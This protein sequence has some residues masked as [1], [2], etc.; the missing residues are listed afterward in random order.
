MELLSPGLS[1]EKDELY[2]SEETGRNRNSLTTSLP[3]GMDKW[4]KEKE[5]Y[6]NTQQE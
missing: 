3:Y 2:G 4:R 6:T 5:N 1:Q